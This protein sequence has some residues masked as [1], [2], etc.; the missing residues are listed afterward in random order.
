MIAG[1]GGGGGGGGVAAGG[2][3]GDLSG[4]E[5]ALIP[6][7]RQAGS[8]T[9]MQQHELLQ[10]CWDTLAAVLAPAQTPHGVLK[11]ARFRE[12][13]R[14]L[15]GPAWRQTLQNMRARHV[16]NARRDLESQYLHWA[17]A[18]VARYAPNAENV[19]VRTPSGMRHY[20]KV[21]A[22]DGLHDP[23][24]APIFHALACGLLDLAVTLAEEGR[25][26]LT[27]AN[28][29]DLKFRH[30]LSARRGPGRALSKPPDTANPT[31]YE[32]AVLNLLSRRAPDKEYRQITNN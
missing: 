5:I 6:R 32:Q 2:D 1:G 7:L 8:H 29:E 15:D 16:A 18:F 21:F 13:K 25:T 3:G 9:D 10:L 24:W 14:G 30:D 22:E 31:P 26:G 27:E 20:A 17:E 19:S 23:V 4:Q 28:F 12:E 11:A